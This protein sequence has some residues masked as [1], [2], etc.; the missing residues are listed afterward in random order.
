MNEP[1]L[2]GLK[3]EGI[4]YFELRKKDVNLL[5]TFNNKIN[6][7]KRQAMLHVNIADGT[8]NQIVLL[9]Q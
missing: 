4:K 8:I 3:Y 1:L 9:S 6:S 2:N 7:S 5:S